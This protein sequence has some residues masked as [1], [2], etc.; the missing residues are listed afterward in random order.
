MPGAV[1]WSQRRQQGFALAAAAHANRGAAATVRGLSAAVAERALQVATR[2]AATDRDG[3]RAWVRALLQ[4]R[5]PLP[6][7]QPGRPPRALA[8]LAPAVGGATGRS[9]LARAP[10]PRAGFVPD[11]RLLA[12]LRAL[13]ARPEG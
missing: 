4:A 2:M 8:L 3:R 12:L 11:P 1:E 7:A 10:L 5:E 9:W 13:A 6:T